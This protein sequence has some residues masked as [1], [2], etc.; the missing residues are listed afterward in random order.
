[1]ALHGV[2]ADVHGNLE[3]LRAVLARLQARGAE[4]FLCLGDVVGYNAEPDACVAEVR[5]RS[6]EAVAGNHDLISVGRLG[7]ARCARKAA[8]ALRRTRRRLRPDSAAYLSTLPAL[9]RLEGGVVLVHGAV[10]DPEAYVRTAAQVAR[11]AALLEAACPGARLCFYG[12]THQAQ[13]WELREGGVHALPAAG[14]IRLREDATYFINP[15]AV[16]SARQPDPGRAECALFD[17]AART[18]EFVS[19]P[20]DHAAAEES[21]RR[22][23]YRLP[24]WRLK[25]RS[26][27]RLS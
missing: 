11:Q 18:V 12:H 14:T 15:G 25:L 6:M 7:T 3:A 5:G 23:G 9:K 4:S 1:M 27:W 16:D 10:D 22:A 8:Y 17:A 21:A 20:Y 26:A 19:V 13:A 2:L 24:A